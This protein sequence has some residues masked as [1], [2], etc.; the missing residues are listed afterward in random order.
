MNFSDL[1]DDLGADTVDK[2]F[3]IPFYLTPIIFIAMVQGGFA[4][5][6][7]DDGSK[8]TAANLEQRLPVINA[9]DLQEF[10]YL[11]RP[12][13]MPLDKLKRIFQILNLDD[14]Q[15]DDFAENL[16]Q[17]NFVQE[18]V[19]FRNGCLEA[20]TYVAAVENVHEELDLLEPLPEQILR[21][22]ERTLLDTLNDPLIQQN[23]DF[24]NERQRRT[25]EDFMS[26]KKLPSYVNDFFVTGVKDL[27]KNYNPIII[28][29]DD[30]I[31]TLEEL[32]PLDERKFKAK[33][34]E[35]IKR[36]VEGNDLA[37]FN[38]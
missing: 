25:I 15:L 29:A 17:L 9:V 20:V 16:K 19:D 22:W 28:D 4:E 35:F 2:H 30:L 38:E 32:P 37:S 36:L 18:F 23:A 1:F 8:L 14:A 5:I 11:S 27:L 6:T 33:L 31:R 24:L 34:D 13:K 12:G 7:F 3:K 10:R 26:D 21:E